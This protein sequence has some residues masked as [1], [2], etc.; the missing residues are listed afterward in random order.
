[1]NTNIFQGRR[2]LGGVIFLAAGWLSGISLAGAAGSAPSANTGSAAVNPFGAKSGT[3][4]NNSAVA[5]P[6]STVPTNP[7]GPKP[8]AGASSGATMSPDNSGS[9]AT[10]EKF[11]PELRKMLLQRFDKNGDGK[12]D[13][14]ELAEARAVLTGGAN[15]PAPNQGAVAA[16][17][18][19]PLFGLRPLIMKRFDHNGAGT[20][21]AAEMAEVRHL[22]F[23]PAKAAGD[24]AA[25]KKEII[26]QF[27]KNG[28]G[29]LDA[30]ETAAAKAFLQQVQAELDQNVAAG[31]KGAAPSPLTQPPKVAIPAPAANSGDAGMRAVPSMAG[32][33]D[34]N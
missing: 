4:G 26:S 15:S 11:V 19:G 24:L 20:L 9:V 29:K 16:A 18:N 27:D 1:M 17:A 3:S 33:T 12:L 5:S 28:D 14:A 25:L 8:A 13:G 7:F 10:G 23:P 31:G 21:D 6:A 34:D 30:T 22:L 2:K 32:G